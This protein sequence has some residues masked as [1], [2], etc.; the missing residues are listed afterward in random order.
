MAKKKQP[1]AK[2]RRKRLEEFLKPF[3]VTKGNGFRC[4]VATS[5]RSIRVAEPRKRGRRRR[6]PNDMGTFP[7][8][9]EMKLLLHRPPCF[10][11]RPQQS[12]CAVATL[13]VTLLLAGSP[14]LAQP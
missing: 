8:R 12:P 2:Q 5:S 1:S 13:S 11:S 7:G 10:N 6:G 3:R 14:L 4:C 9:D